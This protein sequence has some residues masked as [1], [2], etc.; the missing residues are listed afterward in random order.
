MVE[1]AEAYQRAHMGGPVPM[2]TL[3]L[4]AGCSERGLRDAFRS[5][6][7]TSPSRCLLAERLRGVRRALRNSRQYPTTVTAAATGY[8]FF[9][10]GRFAATYKAAFGETPSQTLRRH[11]GL[12]VT[13]PGG[14]EPS[15]H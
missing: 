7:G 15:C 1:R 6:R 4:I 8:G 10:L 9:E 14:G 12:V 2:A 3:C 13:N 5:V 11:A